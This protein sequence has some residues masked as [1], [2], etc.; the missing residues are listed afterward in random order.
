M[1]DPADRRPISQ[2]P[3][4]LGP[5]PSRIKLGA[6]QALAVVVLVLLWTV[7]LP[8][9]PLAALGALWDGLA[10]FQL[11]M[12]A[13]ETLGLAALGTLIGAMLALGLGLAFGGLRALGG[14]FGAATRALV[15]VPFI[16]LLPI[17]LQSG[18][19]FLGK[20][21]VVTLAAAAPELRAVYARMTDARG[22]LIEMAR[23]SGHGEAALFRLIMVP[24]AL[25]ALIARLPRAFAAA[26]AMTLAVELLTGAGLGGWI[27]Y[28][29]DF[30]SGPDVYA[31]VLLAI[32]LAI[33]ARAVLR[34]LVR[35]LPW[36]GS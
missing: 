6:W 7:A 33:A 27:G 8:T 35:L 19:Q 22:D 24:D 11:A 26:F 34:A 23:A 31:G 4:T 18:G 15:A 21:I 3:P 29:S 13:L 20:L 16:V 17:T 36:S 10:S 30:M 2:R 28:A 9:K 5:R 25:G 12:A 14:L 32:A 1:N